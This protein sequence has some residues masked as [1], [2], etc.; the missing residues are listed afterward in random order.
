MGCLRCEDF[1]SKISET[2]G[3]SLFNLLTLV[4]SAQCLLPERNIQS[5]G[6][7]FECRSLNPQGICRG[8]LLL[9]PRAEVFHRGIATALLHYQQNKQHQRHNAEYG[10]GKNHMWFIRNGDEQ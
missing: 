6:F 4:F 5:R 3:S 8:T 9:K 10:Y 1:I 2:V 7:G